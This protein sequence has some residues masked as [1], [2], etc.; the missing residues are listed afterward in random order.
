MADPYRAG[1]E[2]LHHQPNLFRWR[3]KKAGFLLLG[4]V[5][6]VLLVTSRRLLFLSSGKDGL[7]GQIDVFSETKPTIDQLDLSALER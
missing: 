6:G 3:G 5:L 1:E 2:L 7:V 4:T